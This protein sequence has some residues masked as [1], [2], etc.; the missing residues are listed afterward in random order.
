M[1]LRIK[2]KWDKRDKRHNVLSRIKGK[3]YDQNYNQ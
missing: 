2:Y 1:E 3:H